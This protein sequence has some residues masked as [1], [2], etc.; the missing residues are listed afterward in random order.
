MLEIIHLEIV[1]ELEIK[2]RVNHSSLKQ[3]SSQ[4]AY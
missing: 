3:I 2:I 4:L 1:S